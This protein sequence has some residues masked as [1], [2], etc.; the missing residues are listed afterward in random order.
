M[1]PIACAVV[2]NFIKMHAKNDKLFREAM[3]DDSDVPLTDD[4]ENVG[5]TST[6]VDNIGESSSRAK[7][8]DENEM[9]QFQDA[10]VGIS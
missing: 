10:F 1:I 5:E 4:P 3:N 2:H 6:Q 9:G 7:D 8:L